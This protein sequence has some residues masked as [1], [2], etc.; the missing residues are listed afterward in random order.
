[1]SDS[2]TVIEIN[3]SEYKALIA[4]SLA[5]KRLVEWINENEDVGGCFDF[6]VKSSI[7]NVNQKFKDT[8]LTN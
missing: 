1:M 4:S 6:M 7:D 3:L 5:G 2:N 8:G